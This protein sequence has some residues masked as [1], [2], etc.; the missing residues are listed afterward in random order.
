MK[1]MM[2][3]ASIFLLFTVP[4]SVFAQ[5]EEEEATPNFI[6][7]TYFYCHASKEDQADA[8]VEEKFKPVY[9]AAVEDGSINAWG[10]LAHRVGGKWRRV[11]YH[12]ATGIDA[13]MDANDK[14]YAATG[15]AVGDDTSFGDACPNHD[16]YIWSSENVGGG[17]DRGS[18][19][20]SVY[21]YCDQ[22]KESRADEI[23]K[24]HFAPVYDKLVE[25]GMI[26]SWGWSSHFVGGKVRRLSTMTGADHKAVL[27]ARDAAIEALYADDNEAGAEFGSICTDHVDYMWDIQIENP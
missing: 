17:D 5:E 14:I 19:G 11:L 7:A 10:W 24:E 20:F 4:Q 1:K 9:D 27:K 25:D 3:L 12:S 6:Q 2:I 23:V 8:V 21:F 13:L 15:E 26:N 18:A 16:D 22:A